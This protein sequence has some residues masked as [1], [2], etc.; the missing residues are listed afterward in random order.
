MIQKNDELVVTI[1]NTDYEGKGI[2]RNKDE[3]IFVPFALPNE[4]MKIHII[5]AKKNI[6]VGKIVELITPSP[7]RT[8]PPCPYYKKCGGCDLQHVVYDKQL[9][10]KRCMVSDTMKHVGKLDVKVSDVVASPKVW[11]YRNKLALPINPVTRKVAMFERSS[12]KMVDID[13]CLI[14]GSWHEKVIKAMNTYLQTSNISIYDETKHQGLIRHVVA[15]CVKDNVLVSVVINGKTL[16]DSQLLVECFRQQNFSFGLTLN[17]NQEKSNVIL[18]KTYIHLYGIEQLPVSEFG[19]NYAIDNASFF[20]VN[21]DIKKSIYEKVMEE[22]KDFDVVIDAYS[23]AGLMTAMLGTSC[24]KVIGIEIVPQAVE[25]AIALAKRHHLNN[26]EN[27]CGDCATVLPKI[28]SNKVGAV[29]LD[30]PRKGCDRNVIEALLESYPQKIVYISCNPSTL[31]RD[32]GMLKEK[33]TIT[34]VTPFDMFPQTK[35][36]E[37]VATLLAK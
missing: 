13:Y 11:G 7:Y 4:V 8:Q 5:Y 21:N 2:A 26:V 17:I 14:T 36:I 1:E 9:D 34:S 31:A 15:R 25:S 32:L 29:V 6:K 37:T 19:I 3:I 20:Q 28:L 27:I 33:Y 23:G 10:I 30:P 22:V 12:H 35:H 24:K 16:P 18:G